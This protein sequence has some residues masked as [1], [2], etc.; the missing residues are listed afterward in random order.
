MF[1]IFGTGIPLKNGIRVAIR[2]RDVVVRYSAWHHCRVRGNARL[3]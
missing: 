3:K 1:N 2:K